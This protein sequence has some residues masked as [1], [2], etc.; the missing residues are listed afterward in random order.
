M[1]SNISDLEVLGPCRSL[2]LI[3]SL[4]FQKKLLSF[5]YRK[6]TDTPSEVVRQYT[7]SFENFPMILT[8]SNFPYEHFIDVTLVI[9]KFPETLKNT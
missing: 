2:L 6:F 8:S 1:S 9:H 5:S 3:K 4:V 7:L